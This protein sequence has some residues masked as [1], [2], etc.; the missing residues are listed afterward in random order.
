MTA[1]RPTLDDLDAVY[2][3]QPGW[4]GK[5]NRGDPGWAAVCPYCGQGAS[6]LDPATAGDHL[7]AHMPRCRVDAQRRIAG[8]VPLDQRPP[9]DYSALGLNPDGTR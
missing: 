4:V 3:E 5:L 8:D 6:Y 9:L 1:D 2:P 7:R